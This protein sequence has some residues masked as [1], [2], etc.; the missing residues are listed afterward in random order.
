MPDN[1]CT[2]LQHTY[3]DIIVCIIRA[4]TTHTVCANKRKVAVHAASVGGVRAALH[5][6]FRSCGDPARSRWRARHECALRRYNRLYTRCTVDRSRLPSVAAVVT[7]PVTKT[8][9]KI[10]APRSRQ[11]GPHADTRHAESTGF[12]LTVAISG[13]SRGLTSKLRYC[14]ITGLPALVC[15]PGGVGPGRAW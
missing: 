10:Y 9:T 11:S 5:G 14:N 4:R 3:C 6:E 7:P 8:K 13:E 15:P 2:I 1:R 12:T